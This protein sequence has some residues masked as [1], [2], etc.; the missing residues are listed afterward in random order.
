MILSFDSVAVEM[1]RL[2]STG[3]PNRYI[4][5]LSFTIE[6]MLVPKNRTKLAKI[7]TFPI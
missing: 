1:L 3:N 4:L 2:S 7:V 6:Q 5:I